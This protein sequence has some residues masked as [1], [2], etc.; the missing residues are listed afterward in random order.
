M[1]APAQAP[2]P[3]GRRIRR[4]C[5]I[6]TSSA[7]RPEDVHTRGGELGLRSVPGACPRQTTGLF[8]PA[9]ACSLA[10]YSGVGHAAFL[11]LGRVA[12]ADPDSALTRTLSAHPSLASRIRRLVQERA[13]WLPSLCQLRLPPPQGA[14]GGPAWASRASIAWRTGNTLLAGG[15]IALEDIWRILIGVRLRS[16]AM[17]CLGPPGG[18]RRSVRGSLGALGWQKKRSPSWTLAS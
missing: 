3:N 10:A 14:A 7:L 16:P 17:P 13:L 4:Q 1:P 2:L 11:T 12:S 9:Q 15:R 18:A 5:A 8:R 6:Q